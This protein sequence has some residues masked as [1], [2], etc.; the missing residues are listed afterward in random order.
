MNTILVPPTGPAMTSRPLAVFD[1]L[2]QPRFEARLIESVRQISISITTD[3]AEESRHALS[4]L[5]LRYFAPSLRQSLVRSFASPPI[6][7]GED[8]FAGVKEAATIAEF[9]VPSDLVVKR[10]ADWVERLQRTANEWSSPHVSSSPSGEV[11]LEWWR[12]PRKLT[13]YVSAHTVEYV[14][15]WG[16]SVRNE[17]AEGV[18]KSQT[19]ARD[20]WRWLID[21]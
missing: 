16:K 6:A 1:T 8:L 2:A 5:V 19:E 12:A 20:L 18:A 11:V 14:K 7:R 10:A 15:S 13:V 17:M 3:A 9:Q 21:G 4:E